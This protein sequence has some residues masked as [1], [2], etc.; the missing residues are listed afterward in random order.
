MEFSGNTDSIDFLNSTKSLFPDVYAYAIFFVDR[1]RG[2][3]K[4]KLTPRTAR[5]EARKEEISRLRGMTKEELTDLMTKEEI[6]L[7]G[8]KVWEAREGRTPSKEIR[9]SSIINHRMAR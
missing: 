8:F 4:M 1:S 6:P 9:I 2:V 5:S 7:V 3:T